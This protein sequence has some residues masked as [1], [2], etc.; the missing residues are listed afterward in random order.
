MPVGELLAAGA[1]LDE[2]Y[3]NLDMWAEV[4]DRSPLRTLVRDAEA[5]GVPIWGL[6]SSVFSSVSDT[7]SPQ[8]AIAIALRSTT[9]IAELADHDGAV[10]VCVDV[11]DPGNAGTLVRA[12]EAAGCAGV[13]FAGSCTD[14]F[15]P[16]AVRAA[17]G[18]VVRLPIAEAA[19]IEG[20]LAEL[21]S[22]GR[23]LVATVVSGGEAP[24][25]IDLSG[26]VAVLIGSE[27]HGLPA[28]VAGSCDHLLTIPM[29]A[30]VESINAAVAGAVV[31]FETARQRRQA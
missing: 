17:A 25:S 11:S 21:R 20:A 28:E 12:A 9:T 30:S 8:G 3:V 10:L 5:A 27:A 6:T 23:S 31:L 14:P 24:E 18:S 1:D 22:A 29:S 13:V 7:K 15:G 19:D 4:D 2:V 26:S 16:K